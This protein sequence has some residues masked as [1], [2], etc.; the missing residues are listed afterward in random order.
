MTILE[1]PKNYNEMLGKLSFSTLLSTF[2]FCIVLTHFGL[3]P[4]I[5]SGSIRSLSP[6]VKDQEETL[7]W[8]F[9]FGKIPVISAV[10]AGIFSY[11]FGLHNI[12]AKSISLRYFWDKHFVIG[13]LLKKIKLQKKLTRKEVSVAMREFYYPQV[14]LIS[15]KHYVH[16]FWRYTLAFWILFEHLWIALFTTIYLF[17][18]YDNHNQMYLWLYLIILVTIACFQWYFVTVRKSVDIA[19]QIPKDAIIKY[20]QPNTNTLLCTIL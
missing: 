15:D 20:F 2:I 4:N 3:I 1:S 14:S 12:L 8:L 7:K 16:V 19:E 11:F 13:T 18:K 10:C 5:D 17:I 9:S 6:P